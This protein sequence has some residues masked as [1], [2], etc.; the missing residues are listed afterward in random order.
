MPPATFEKLLYTRDV[1]YSYTTNMQ[2]LNTHVSRAHIYE[3]ITVAWQGDIVADSL[4]SM[5]SP[6]GDFTKL[7]IKAF[8]FLSLDTLCKDSSIT[9]RNI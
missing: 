5:F 7:A 4:Q 2:I 9:G 6:I 1:F 3:L 8:V